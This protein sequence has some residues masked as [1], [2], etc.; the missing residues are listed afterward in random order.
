MLDNST[1]YSND[2]YTQSYGAELISQRLTE[3]YGQK[4]LD[5]RAAWSRT[6]K[7]ELPDFPLNLSLDLVDKCNLAC[8]QCLRSV[9]LVKDYKGYLNTNE[10]LTTESVIRAFDECYDHGM[11][12]LNIGGSGEPTMHSDIAKICKAAMD[13]DI[14][15]LR[16]ITNGLRL[17]EPLSEALIDMQAHV[18]SVSI[19][20]ISAETFGKVRGKEHRYEQVVENILRFLEIRKRRNSIFPLLR[21]TFVSQPDNRHEKEGFIEFWSDHADM[22]D[23]QSFH[24]FRATEFNREFDCT[25]PFRRLIIWAKGHVG[26]CCGFP[27]S[28]TIWVI[29]SCRACM[30]SGMPS[31]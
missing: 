8:P 12:S 28:F 29:T 25:E 10:I 17:D 7:F 27:E 18:L 3:R 6:E 13:R 22:I 31:R 5:Y 11:P 1:G 24:D 19:D 9:D 30:K 14:L 23:V 2:I 15:E 20:A 26:P 21:V 16:L 4:Y